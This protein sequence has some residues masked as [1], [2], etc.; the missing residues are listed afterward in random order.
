MRAA[1][2]GGE[3]RS[4]PGTVVKEQ[5]PDVRRLIIRTSKQDGGFAKVAIKD[6]GPGIKETNV[7]RIFDPFYTTKPEGLGMGLSI[8]Q[9][10]IKAH[11]GT[12]E[13]SNNQE[14]GATFYFTV[15][16]ARREQS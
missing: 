15:R 12:M 3:E 11:G 16:L 1:K 9:T 2:I 6:A 4:W 14:G 7:G 10:I 5:E 8:S 13:A